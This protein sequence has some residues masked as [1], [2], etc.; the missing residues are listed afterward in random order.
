M[1][2]RIKILL[3]FAI[4]LL[5][6]FSFLG[7]N[8]TAYAQEDLQFVMI[9]GYGEYE[10]QATTAVLRFNINLQKESFEEGQKSINEAY[11]A[12]LAKVKEMNKDNLIYITYSS[13]YPNFSGTLKTYNFSCSFNIKTKD[14]ATIDTLV[15]ICGSENDISFYGCDYLVDNEQEFYLQALNKAKEDAISK[16]KNLNENLDLKA[17]IGTNVYFNNYDNSEKIKIK[18]EIKCVFIKTDSQPTET[19]TKEAMV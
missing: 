5:C 12:I 1:N 11:D 15:E 6:A 17:I 7:Q 13:C 4:A 10:T 14:F 19:I 9:N 3:T 2:K 16:A 8:K 18:A